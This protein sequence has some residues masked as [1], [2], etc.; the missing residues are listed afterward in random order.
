MKRI[1]TIFSLVMML[2]STGVAF[3]KNLE[4]EK[5]VDDYKVQASIDKNPPVVGKN[6]IDVKIRNN[7]GDIINDAQ[8]MVFYSMP[9]MPGMPAMNYHTEAKK[10]GSSYRTAINLSMA[11]PWNI[12][13][14]FKRAN[15]AIKDI[16]FSIDVR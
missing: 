5:S 4:V 7:S 1:L 11:G 14:K 15:E 6:N 12:Q 10:D 3:S 13:I 8:V 9:A 16:K 2:L